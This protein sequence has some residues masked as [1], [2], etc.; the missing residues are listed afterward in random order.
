MADKT[1]K[2]AD[3]GRILSTIAFPYADL[4]NAIEVARAI[5]DLGGVGCTRDQ[6]ASQMEQVPTSG[7]FGI[8]LGAAR[9]FG[10]V[11]IV[12]AQKYG[13]TQLGFA[14]LDTNESRV[15]AAKVEAFLSVPL[16]KKVYEEYRNKLLPPRMG[17]EQAFVSF[18]V[19]VRQKDKARIVFERSAQQAGF[20]NP[21]KDRLVAPVVVEGVMPFPDEKPP[22]PPASPPP[23]P[24]P[25]AIASVHPLLDGL[26]KEIPPTNQ[27]W[28]V[29]AQ[30]RWLQTAANVFGLLYGKD[31]DNDAISIKVSMEGPQK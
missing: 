27:S 19:S 12:S 9:M 20:F 11:E 26:F 31:E 22:Q 8:K 30:A 1:Q 23:A 10:L 28:S 13:N 3:Q 24:S 25:V 29:A 5:L 7:A 16:Y 4:D 17:L 2:D 6:L 14:I 21:A 18:G 15:Q